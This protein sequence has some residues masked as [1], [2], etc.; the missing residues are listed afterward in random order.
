MLP[1]VFTT[2]WSWQQDFQVD[3]GM[4]GLQELLEQLQPG[5]SHLPPLLEVGAARAPRST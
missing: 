3:Q 4:S 2:T 1:N 5:A